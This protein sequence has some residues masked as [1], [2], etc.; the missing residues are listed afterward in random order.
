MLIHIE[1]Q[2]SHTISLNVEED[3]TVRSV[4]EKIR[5]DNRIPIELQTVVFNGK[6][7]ADEDTLGRCGVYIEAT[8]QLIV[9]KARS[10]TL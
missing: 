3:T 9:D 4:K 6:W 1:T 5:Q 8:L 7:L 10:P 2:N